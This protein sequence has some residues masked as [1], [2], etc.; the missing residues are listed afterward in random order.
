MANAMDAFNLL[1]TRVAQGEYVGADEAEQMVVAHVAAGGFA[2]SSTAFKDAC[3]DCRACLSLPTL[4][5]DL[6]RP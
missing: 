2:L 6:P 1:Q 4:C 3:S 5:Q